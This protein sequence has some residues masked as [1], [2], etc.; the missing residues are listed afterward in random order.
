MALEVLR[1]AIGDSDFFEVLRRWATENPYGSAE[2]D[3]LLALVLE[4]AGSV[5]PEFQDWLFDQGRPAKP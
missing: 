3:D 4:V 5:P 1:Q 2:T